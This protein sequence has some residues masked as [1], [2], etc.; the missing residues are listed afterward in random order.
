MNHI[1]LGLSV[2]LFC[3]FLAYFI[4]S[5]LLLLTLFCVILVGLHFKDDF[6]LFRYVATHV[7][8]F[9]S[10][11]CETYTNILNMYH[12][13]NNTN[14]PVRKCLD[15]NGTV[16]SSKL[17]NL[18]RFK[19][20]VA[21]NLNS[22]HLCETQSPVFNNPAWN[23]R[24]STPPKPNFFLNRLQ[25]A[26]H[27]TPTL[28]ISN[29]Y[30][31]E[32]KGYNISSV[33]PI[34]PM[35]ASNKH[36]I[37]RDCES[38]LNTVVNNSYV[39]TSSGLNS[40]ILD[41]KLYAN[42]NSP[43]FCS[44]VAERLSESMT[45]QPKYDTVGAFPVVNFK[46]QSSKIKIKT[47]VRV[48]LA[49]PSS[50]ILFSPTSSNSVT[51]SPTI[52]P[53]ESMKSVLQVLK[54]ISR[55]RI[56]SH[57]DEDSEDNSKRLRVSESQ[58]DSES[59]M[60]TSLL[61]QTIQGKRAREESS[62]T[63]DDVKKKRKPLQNN[64][65]LSSLS[66]SILIKP[67]HLKTKKR[68]AQAIDDSVSSIPVLGKLLKV[69]TEVTPPSSTVRP[70]SYGPST[71]I[72]TSPNTSQVIVNECKPKSET[73][74]N[75]VVKEHEEKEEEI[76]ADAADPDDG[77]E[78]RLLGRMSGQVYHSTV[79]SPTVKSNVFMSTNDLSLSPP[80]E[81]RLA[82]M[83]AVLGGPSENIQL[84]SA[85]I[86]DSK[87]P[88]RK[89]KGKALFTSP[90]TPEISKQ[91]KKVTFSDSLTTTKIYD[92]DQTQTEHSSNRTSVVTHTSPLSSLTV[93]VTSSPT[94]TDTSGIASSALSEAKEPVIQPK[95]TIDLFTSSTSPKTSTMTSKPIL[96]SHTTNLTSPL[97]TSFKTVESQSVKDT[98]VQNISVNNLK[99]V[100]SFGS[101]NASVENNKPDKSTPSSISDLG[102]KTP[103]SFGSSL[104]GTQVSSPN[105]VFTPLVANTSQNLSTKSE[106]SVAAN[107]E[108]QNKLA[109]SFGNTNSVSSP[110]GKNEGEGNQVLNGLTST[111]TSTSNASPFS[112]NNT[113]KQIFPSVS[114]N[115]NNK[116]EVPTFSFGSSSPFS[117]NLTSHTPTTKTE[118]QNVHPA[119]SNTV[120]SSIQP[121]LSLSAQ[122]NIPFSTALSNLSQSSKQSPFG[123]NSQPSS[124]NNL[125]IFGSGTSQNGGEFKITSSVASTQVQAQSSLFGN[126]ITQAAGFGVTVTSTS[127]GGII[128]PTTIQ[129]NVTNQN[130]SLFGN[131]TSN[132]TPKPSAFNAGATITSQQPSQIFGLP[133]AT[134]SSQASSSPFG[135]SVN[136]SGPQPKIFGNPST[137][138][139]TVFGTATTNTV[140]VNKTSFLNTPSTAGQSSVFSIS[141][142]NQLSKPVF[143]SSSTASPSFGGLNNSN[144]TFGNTNNANTPTF[145][146]Q[147]NMNTP[148]FGNQNN[149]NTPAFGNQNN[150]TTPTFGN[151]N[152]TATPAFGNQNNTATPAFGN[153]NN[154]ATPAFGNQNNTATPAFGNQNNTT[155]AAFGNQNNTVTP[156]FGNQNNT[157]VS[158]FGSQTNT[159]N[160][161]QSGFGTGG[162]LSTPGAFS[163]G[164][165]SSSNTTEVKASTFSQS[166]F[167]FGSSAVAK[168][169]TKPFAAAAPFSFS[170]NTQPNATMASSTQSAQPTFG[171][172]G[173][174]FGSS[175]Q[176]P[177]FGSSMAQAP[178]PTFAFSQAPAA[179]APAFQFSATAPQP[180]GG[181]FSIGSGSSSSR[182]KTT[183]LRRR[184]KQ[185]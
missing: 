86:E 174:G 63:E 149:M 80:K 79:Q 127:S 177:A 83:I 35:N 169:P 153:Q 88:E 159:L 43:G 115:S 120:T 156:A 168:E 105:S 75:S 121:S 42:V 93:G 97:N 90:E 6:N 134:A 14:F 33:K 19:G 45:H 146:N 7:A 178:T 128:L 110:F 157:T 72:N 69:Q 20:N 16:R 12:Q 60:H 96:S 109:F 36:T 161:S 74:A 130:S 122:P 30:I 40:P 54:D 113:N 21:H 28:K 85:P 104:N 101:T 167:V 132:T 92:L 38:P 53:D 70:A 8:S 68:K 76:V 133:V 172:L 119:V 31:S 171:A 82:A 18:H 32:D 5:K 126:A 89:I 11:I 108:G 99:P 44:R 103:F 37:P 52:G 66:S 107:K 140:S 22:S 124:Q 106:T 162:T 91:N 183:A 125:S 34:S 138:Q 144:P 29:I 39:D 9:Y 116:S 112:Q 87:Q 77:V 46:N 4:L 135:V 65:I 58:F 173:T 49:P 123:S 48:R 141:D 102:A 154:T 147:N 139:T 143:A 179:P 78:S 67:P 41:A 27:E 170:S 81:N 160:T 84:D 142:G 47:P 118:P 181:M 151:Q 131:L 114:T 145:G 164:N 155:T 57:V 50:D 137:T 166:P 51:R 15:N 150:T 148:A 129:Q 182:S 17:D 3:V 24:P 180:A 55:K 2:V 61:Q 163:L 98:K 100:F 13:S 136:S 94:P 111:N 184:Q 71:S 62:P 152:N 176:T 56:H 25:S 117:T 185:T 73:T 1:Y 175:Q 165:T 59:V 64:E 95:S 158:G 10:W 26:R 23:S